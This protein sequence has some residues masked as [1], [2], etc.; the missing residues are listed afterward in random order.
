MAHTGE[1]AGYDIRAKAC[2]PPTPAPRQP[3]GQ[4][5]KVSLPG[6]PVGA[7]ALGKLR[8]PTWVATDRDPE[9]YLIRILFHPTDLLSLPLAMSERSSQGDTGK[10]ASSLLSH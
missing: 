1:L 7:A 3:Q 8:T 9:A 10:F 6:T 5:R 2:T 4:G